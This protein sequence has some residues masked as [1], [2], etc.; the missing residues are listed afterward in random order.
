MVTS[1]FGLKLQLHNGGVMNILKKFS[2][3]AVIPFIAGCANTSSKAPT[4]TSTGNDEPSEPVVVYSSAWGDEYGETIVKNLGVDIPYI[5]NQ[6]F[7]VVETVDN[8]GDPLICIYVY[9]YEGHDSVSLVE[10]YAVICANQGYAVESGVQSSM[11]E[12]YVITTYTVWYADGWINDV[13]AIEIQFLEGR[14]NGKYA[15]GI[16]A[17]NYVHYDEH[18]WPSNVVNSLLGHDVPGIDE[19]YYTYNASIKVDEYGEK[20]I[21]IVIDGAW[22][23]I[24]TEYL[25]LLESSGYVIDDS[26]YDECGYFALPL[27]GAEYMDH[28]I[29]FAYSDWYGLEILIVPLDMS[30]L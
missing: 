2:L 27:N 28:G 3:L 8:Y 17:F 12:N 15:L 13:D 6:G 23:D 10:D 21:Y 1:L 9:E 4:T 29:Q 22:N 5:E 7:D 25:E 20:F 14:H 24:E 18:A 26:E 19:S 16:F 11:D 30:S